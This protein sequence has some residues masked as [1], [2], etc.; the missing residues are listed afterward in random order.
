MTF[1][2][3]LKDEVP[4]DKAHCCDAMTE[5]VNLGF[6]QT[7][8]SLKGSTDR[9]IYWS[10]V[11]DEYGLICQPSAEMLLIQY[12]PFCGVQLPDS[13]RD[14]WFDRLERHGWKTWDDSIPKHMLFHDWAY[15]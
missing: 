5:Q 7:V 12:C 13:R 11:F 10:P 2:L 14:M 15:E 6:P 8:G 4:V 3:V 1:A 9:R